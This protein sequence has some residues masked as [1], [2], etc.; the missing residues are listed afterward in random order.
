[1]KKS[2]K[3][4]TALP[5]VTDWRTS[6]ADEIAR[7][8][9]RARVE[10]FHI[11]NLDSS[12]PVFSN[13]QIRSASGMTYQVEIRDVTNRQM[14][15]TCTDFRINGLGTCKHIEA[16]LLVL[17][18]RLRAQFRTITKTGSPCAEI[19]PEGDSLRVERGADVLPPALRQHF[20]ETGLL[21]AHADVHETLKA[22][23]AL[24]RERV[25]LSQ[26]VAP[27]LEARRRSE[28]RVL[29][30]RD[31]EAGVREGR[32]P[33]HV[34]HSP[35]F[36]YQ[37]E[38]M[39]HLAFGERVM[40]A[41]EMGLGKTIQA[42]AAC[43]LLHHL[44][45]AERVLVVTPASL[46]TEWEEQIQ[47]FTPLSLRLVF[48]GKSARAALYA[49][50]TPPFFT[51][52]NYEQIVR[53][54]L[55]INE[56][57]RPDIII[58]D[59]AQRIKN[60]S[61]KIAQSVKRLQSRY[62]F[63]LT[64]T[65]I[66]NRI[67]ELRSL[68]DFLNPATLGPL[69]RFNREFYAFD[70]RGRPMNYQNLDLLRERIR[71]IVLR[72]RKADVETELPDRTDRNHFVALTPAMRDEY[73]SYEKQ[74]AEL[75][76]RAK[77]RPLTPKE[78]DLL[79]IL[80]NIM[81]MICDSP[82]LIKNNPCS[83]CPKIDELGR[84]LDETLSSPDVKVIIFSEWVG[85]LEKVRAWAEKEDIGF[86]WHTGSV[87]QKRRR[88]E[89]LAFR[90]D[91]NCRLFLSTDSGG[92]GLNLQ[93]ASVVINC[94]LPWNPAKLEQRI[95]RAW[96]KNQRHPVT[97][98][99]LV[100]ERTIEHGMLS[101]LA[102]K[103]QLA[104][105]VLDGVGDL[106]AIKLKGGG[107]AFLKRLEQVMAS[108]PS[109]AP[110]PAPAPPSDPATDFAA[111]A[112]QNLGQNL[113]QCDEKWLPNSD[114]PVV[115]AVLRNA[116]PARRAVIE[117]TFHETRWNHQQ[118]TLQVL[119]DATWDALQNLA[120]AGM[121]TLHTRATRPLLLPVG[122]APLTADQLARIVELRSVAEKK[123]RAATALTAAGLPEEAA[124]MM[125][126]AESAESQALAIE[127]G[128]SA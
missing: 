119:D 88:A 33:E 72:R 115:V 22:L 110:T 71:P 52:A 121:I 116:T 99:N 124:P 46:K 3:P 78:H 108:I 113:V 93:N 112:R 39:L 103:S 32:H 64:G 120:D 92:V 1:M 19:V 13:F 118:P 97:V 28:E 48:G 42:I 70:E 62:A 91:P 53:D 25:R 10:R 77:K 59:E 75:L 16:T 96:R 122:R 36:P 17:A 9:E 67:D 26:E 34:T 55:D 31:Y 107:Q 7:R 128:D 79:M 76:H 60:W 126:A 45:K 35:L 56:R 58:L 14:S 40:L 24:P 106:A 98:I 81:R 100:A 61:T 86:A 41:D 2:T 6:D 43:A 50:P 51:I 66:E 109:P 49:Q 82:S 21:A 69:F 20:D 105:G 104:S 47:R 30:R 125:A 123:R 12:Q 90:Q 37:R 44:G 84:I 114:I 54:S 87:P 8:K 27:W 83:D 23:A 101:T 117:K 74:V 95:A 89:I 63:V 4:K 68:V 15:C 102:L 80:L 5:P 85:M 127:A 65:P 94:D 73:S 29:L 18:R 11:R 111:R 57:L 38:G